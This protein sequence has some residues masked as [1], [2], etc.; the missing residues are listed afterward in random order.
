M[1]VPSLK[2]SLSKL[3]VSSLS[4]FY[5]THFVTFYESGSSVVEVSCLPGLLWGRMCYFVHRLKDVGLWIVFPGWQPTHLPV[6]WL[7]P[8][9]KLKTQ[10]ISID[11]MNHCITVHIINNVLAVRFKKK[12]TKS[13][14]M[15]WVS[16]VIIIWTSIRLLPGI[17]VEPQKYRCIYKLLE[18][19]PWN[20]FSI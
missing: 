3:Q 20:V 4:Q 6:L 11:C 18:A 14:I 13:H 8:P 7:S 19:K 17:G 5:P 10:P 2:E 16:F 9:V 15:V 12:T 1:T